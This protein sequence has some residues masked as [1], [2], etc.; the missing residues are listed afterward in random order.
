[1]SGTDDFRCQAAAAADAIAAAIRE[2]RG[3]EALWLVPALTRQL[4]EL[5]TAGDAGG[6][7]EMGIEKARAVLGDLA[8]RAA[9]NGTVTWLTDRGR[10][11]A[12]IAP[13]AMA[14]AAAWRE[15]GL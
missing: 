3:G 7:H 2:G 8:R 14:E 9:E 15:D 13:V 12:A 10:H 1:M 6:E 5:L 4:A 11:V